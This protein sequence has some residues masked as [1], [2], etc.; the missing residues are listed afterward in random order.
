MEF[1]REPGDKYFLTFLRDYI[2]NDDAK[3][4]QKNVNRVYNQ[5]SKRFVKKNIKK[6]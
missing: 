6:T 4:C 1:V 5:Y 3:N 2:E